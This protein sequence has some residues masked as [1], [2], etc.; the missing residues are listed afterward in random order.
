MAV[1]LSEYYAQQ[2]QWQ[3]SIDVAKVILAHYPNYAYAM[4]KVGRNSIFEQCSQANQFNTINVKEVDMN[5]RKY[6]TTSIVT[7]LL[8]CSH[9]ASARFYA[10][11]PVSAQ[12]QLQQ[13][14]VQGF[15]RY[16]Y[17]NNNPY[18]FTVQ[19]RFL[20]A[21]PLAHQHTGFAA[22]ARADQRGVIALIDQAL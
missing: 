17:A 19:R 11:N 18:K 22:Q 15:N 2:Q 10:N 6:L 9:T 20:Q 4:L 16:V 1:V 3:R 12:A 21:R 13:G 5:N 8:C 7:A 14:N